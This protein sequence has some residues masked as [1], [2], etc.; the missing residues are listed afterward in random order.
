MIQEKKKKRVRPAASTATP[1]GNETP[2]HNS[3]LFYNHWE[4]LPL[5]ACHY[6]KPVPQF[7]RII[8]GE[9]QSIL[10]VFYSSKRYKHSSAGLADYHVAPENISPARRWQD[11]LS[12]IWCRIFLRVDFSTDSTSSPPALNHWVGGRRRDF[13]LPRICTGACFLQVLNLFCLLLKK[14]TGL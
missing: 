11:Y 13:I 3:S 1:H 14:I 4:L 12:N 8:Q 10:S 2:R 7:P 9:V 6:R 5:M